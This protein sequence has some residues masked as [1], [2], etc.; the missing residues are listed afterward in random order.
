MHPA[1]G[2]LGGV[3]ED[4]SDRPEPDRHLGRIK[5]ERAVVIATVGA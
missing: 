2:L 4:V 1:L 5:M 3:D